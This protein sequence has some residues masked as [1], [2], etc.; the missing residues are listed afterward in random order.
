VFA[1]S[2]LRAVAAVFS[3]WH[4]KYL[5]DSMLEFNTPAAQPVWTYVATWVA[6]VVG[7]CWMN[8]HLF[9]WLHDEAKERW[10]LDAQQAMSVRAIRHLNVSDIH[11]VEH[12]QPNVLASREKMAVMIGTIGSDLPKYVAGACIWVY[13]LYAALTT[14]FWFGVVTLGGLALYAWCTFQVSP[15]V[16][17][18]FDKKQDASIDLQVHERKLLQERDQLRD[19]NQLLFLFRD[20]IYSGT[21]RELQTLKRYWKRF[22][23]ATL[24]SNLRLIRYNQMLDTVFDLTKLLAGIA[25]LVYCYWGGIG[26][27]TVAF[28]YMLLPKAAEPITLYR[29]L[30]RLMLEAQFFVNWYEDTIRAR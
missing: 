26:P 6:L 11:K 27:G 10:L 9:T 29:A 3:E 4:W 28:L 18:H 23:L 19:E 30:Q 2:A 25:L 24:A 7:I 15:R 21:T 5:T 8:D 13:V 12:M 20:A 1:T 17:E 22:R 14:M 16:S